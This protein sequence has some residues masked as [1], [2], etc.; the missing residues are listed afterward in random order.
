[1]YK[2]SSS[3]RWLPTNLLSGK[4]EDDKDK[5]FDG[6]VVKIRDRTLIVGNSIYQISNISMIE[7][8]DLSTEEDV[9]TPSIVIALILI[10]LL[11]ILT[12]LILDMASDLRFLLGV[13]SLSLI[14]FAMFVNSRREKKKVNAAFALYVTMNS[15]NKA[16]ILSDDADILKQMMLVLFSVMNHKQA[17]QQVN[18]NLDQRQIYDLNGSVFSSGNVSGD[19]VNIV[20]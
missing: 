13:L 3:N 18:F 9:P 7:V 11:L 6:G 10:G 14:G 15:G 19:I 2:F 17:N 16:S 8:A 1:M 5:E 4:D 12:S 20:K